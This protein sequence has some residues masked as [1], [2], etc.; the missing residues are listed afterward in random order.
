MKSLTCFPLDTD[1][2]N[3]LNYRTNTSLLLQYRKK[4]IANKQDYWSYCVLII[5]IREI[6][7]TYELHIKSRF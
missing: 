3:I 1:L 2:N 7:I 5:T 6:A 4:A